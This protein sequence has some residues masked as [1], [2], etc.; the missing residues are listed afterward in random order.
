MRA[1]RD[2]LHNPDRNMTVM[3]SVSRI[4][5]TLQALLLSAHPGPSLAVTVLS[6]LLAIGAG[7]PPATIVV[8]GAAI[9][10]GQL[11]IGW[12]NDLIDSDRDKSAGRTDKP[13]AAGLLSI[14]MVWMALVIAAV[15]CVGLSALLGWR[16]ASVHLLLLVG[17]G[18]VYNIWLKSTVWSWLPYLVAFGS[19]PSIVDLAGPTAKLAPWWMT[20]TAAVL[21]VAAHLLNALGDLDIDAR[22]GVRGLPHRLGATWTTRLAVLLLGLGS[23]VVAFGPAGG[24]RVWSWPLLAAI[25]VL[26]VIASRGKGRRPFQAAILIA[27]LDAVMLVISA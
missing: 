6:I 5:L 7:L 24:V 10:L 1:G 2:L 8:L 18:Q 20:V 11:T 22:T 27:I 26:L 19:L 16:S 9:A 12:V 13:V 15:G 23:A 25:V 4:R 3:P 21:G 14:R 17:G